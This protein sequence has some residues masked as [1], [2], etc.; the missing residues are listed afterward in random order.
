M[1]FG[2]S[3]FNNW[4]YAHSPGWECFY[5][6]NALRARFTDYR[7]VDYNER[8]KGGLKAVGWSKNDLE[9]LILWNYA[10]PERFSAAKMRTV[11]DETRAS[12]RMM[13]GRTMADLGKVLGDVN[14]ITILA[15]GGTY[16]VLLGGGWRSRFIPA[17]SLLIAVGACLVIF[18]YYRLPPRV[19]CPAFGVA[20][21]VAI[22]CSPAE[23]R[24]HAFLHQTVGGLLRVGLVV[25][26]AAWLL[27]RAGTLFIENAQELEG[28]EV[29]KQMIV[30]LEPT[31]TQLFVDWTGIFPYE[32]LVYPLENPSA[33]RCFRVIELLLANPRTPFSAQR[34]E[35]R[36]I[37]DL[38]RALYERDDMFLFSRP[39][40]NR[41]LVGYVKEHYGVLIGGHVKL[42]HPGL[43]GDYCYALKASA[44]QPKPPPSGL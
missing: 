29:A 37:T 14:L 36:G 8:T 27:W 28:H 41:F 43:R 31:E 39:P 7:H 30:E 10:D 16:L 23:L 17:L 15:V 11:L 19:S 4:Y 5:E 21:A 44:S 33:P 32:D 25:L 38:Y 12:D 42:S 9:M 26:V 13:K 3:W 1:C 6:F 34:F 2:G 40:L 24:D 35:E 20:T 18:W 22:I